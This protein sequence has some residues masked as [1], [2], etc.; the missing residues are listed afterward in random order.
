MS[1][2]ALVTGASR[3]IG[4]AIASRLAAG[5]WN[6]T[7]AAR[8]PE[9]LTALADRLRAEY[10]VRVHTT[11]GDM[12]VE[13][14]IHEVARQHLTTYDDRLD[15]LVLS[16]GMGQAGSIEGFPLSRLDKQ[17]AVN[18]RAPF[19]LV[20]ECLPALR[21]TAALGPD[22]VT[23]V[24][25]GAKVVAVAS[26]TG[27]VAEPSLS[28]YAATKAAL[29]SLCESVN[30]EESEA[31]VSACAVAPGYVDTDMTSWMH[32]RLA[33]EEMITAADVAEMV[34]SVVALSRSAVVPSI[35]I[36]RPGRH[37]WRA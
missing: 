23:G 24:C 16:A 29:L 25:H 22:E 13:A 6:L 7:L 37:L 8:T 4:A 14:D 10:G 35:A 30:V 15:A 21:A 31:G 18:L 11:P 27:M 3:G 36:T 12:A 9:P 20:Q 2:T 33:R 1:R 5:G 32:D 34:A 28:A 17:Y 26:L 19:Q